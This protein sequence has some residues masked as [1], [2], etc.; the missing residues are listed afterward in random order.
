MWTMLLIGAGLLAAA[1]LALFVIVAL[2]VEDW[3]RDL[4]TNVATTDENSPDERMRPM[5]APLDPAALAEGTENAVKSLANW[6]LESSS[7]EGSVLT[8]HFVRTTPLM[9]FQ[10]DIH[11]RIEPE[12]EGRSVLSAV[13]RSR[14]GKGDLGQNPRNLRELLV[15]VRDAIR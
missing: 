15:A 12:A 11:V 10:D 4:T 5:H 1:M 6:R 13:S 7:R 2:Q 3:Q 8:L 14:V 9:R